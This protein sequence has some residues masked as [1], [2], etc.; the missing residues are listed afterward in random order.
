MEINISW[1]LS[2]SP[3]KR[4]SDEKYHFTGFI[5]LCYNILFFSPLYSIISFS[6]LFIRNIQ[7]PDH[8]GA[9][10]TLLLSCKPDR[11]LIYSAIY[12][13]LNFNCMRFHEKKKSFDVLSLSCCDKRQN[14]DCLIILKLH[15]VVLCW[16]TSLLI[17]IIHSF[18]QC[19]MDSLFS[20]LP[21]FIHSF[22]YS[23]IEACPSLRGSTR[24]PINRI[25]AT[26][27]VKTQRWCLV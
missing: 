17:L 19:S 14:S 12:S 4:F 16:C 22:V 25:T 15:S 27:H 5:I 24:F 9:D 10:P 3:F 21:S 13:I 11:K 18:L 23:F 8:R 1:R 6:A 20:F 2:V 26:C 7:K